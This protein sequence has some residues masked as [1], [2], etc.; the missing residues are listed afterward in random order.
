MSLKNTDTQE[1]PHLNHDKTSSISRHK[2]GLSKKQSHPPKISP[3]VSDL[4]SL[5]SLTS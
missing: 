4:E 2:S 1:V 3:S 5:K